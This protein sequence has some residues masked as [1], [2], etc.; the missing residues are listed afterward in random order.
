MVA[1][2]GAT[3]M[4]TP[5]SAMRARTQACPTW[6]LLSLLSLLASVSALAPTEEI[7]AAGEHGADRRE[8][9]AADN[10]Y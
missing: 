1:R 10:A 3:D 6:R 9:R 4:S 7:A 5:L 8:V 2:R